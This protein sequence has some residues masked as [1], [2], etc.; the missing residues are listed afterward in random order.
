[1]SKP[2]I[3]VRRLESHPSYL[4]QLRIL[5]VILVLSVLS[6]II[7]LEIGR[8]EFKPSLDD[9]VAKPRIEISV[10]AARVD[11]TVDDT[12]PR[13]DRTNNH[14]LP[15]PSESD[16]TPNLDDQPRVEI[17]VNETSHL[18]N[19]EKTSPRLNLTNNHLSPPQS[20][21]DETPKNRGDD[22][23]NLESSVNETTTTTPSTSRKQTK[24]R[25]DW[26]NLP[27][28]SKL[29]R[30]MLAHQGD[31]SLPLGNVI[32]RNQYGLGSDLHF[33]S[34]AI[35]HGMEHKVRV[36]TLFPW[37]WM[38]QGACK[39]A[40]SPMNCYFPQSELSCPGD[41][42]LAKSHPTSFGS[43]L[44]NV[45]RT[46]GEFNGGCN[47][48]MQGGV[49]KIDIQAA[50]TE[51]LFRH[52]SSHVVE[53]AERQFSLV[54][55][56]DEA[57]KDLITVHIR[58]GDKKQEMSLISIRSYINAITRLLKERNR[59]GDRANIFLATEDPR[60]LETFRKRAP[61]GW[62]IYVDQYYHEMLDHRIE[63][64]NGIPKMAAALEGRTGTVA[65]GSL[66]VA[67]EANDYVLTSASNWSRMMN[68]LREKILDPRCNS[69][70]KM[71]DLRRKKRETW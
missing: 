44:F 19:V 1:M 58:W 71:E 47:S 18:Y 15:P 34:R 65:L 68:E 12:N 16:Q 5:F 46:D 14:H 17:S 11:T 54:F 39:D 37:L 32:S 69:C 59:A 28:Q 49:T 67:M 50:G 60:A 33:W 22:N 41:A 35:C 70:T 27:P 55:G 10:N 31:C 42:E 40:T 66:L 61:P 2:T 13:F 36:R 7:I 48:V 53:E 62:R 45:S 43:R 63:G 9:D 64:Y 8:G 23:L 26:T 3:H 51:L 57:P 30:R 4:N 52:V 20:E 24:L 25:F 21:A 29:A 6:L 56:G 38:D